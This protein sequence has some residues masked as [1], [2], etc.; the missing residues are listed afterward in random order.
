MVA[1]RDAYIGALTAQIFELQVEAMQ[2]N[3]AKHE[4]DKTTTQPWEKASVRGS[5]KIFASEHKKVIQTRDC[6]SK[7]ISKRC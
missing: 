6:E 2:H 7:N 1:K 4:S 5:N 3:K